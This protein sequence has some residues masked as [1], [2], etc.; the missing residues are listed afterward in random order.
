MDSNHWILSLQVDMYLDASGASTSVDHCDFITLEIHP[1]TTLSS[2][3][4]GSMMTLNVMSMEILSLWL[5]VTV[6]TVM[7]S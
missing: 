4:K 2:R 3:D 6:M 1:L 7:L 5:M